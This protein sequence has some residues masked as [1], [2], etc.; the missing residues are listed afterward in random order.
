VGNRAWAAKQ[1]NSRKGF[2]KG[3]GKAVPPALWV[4]PQTTGHAFNGWDGQLCAA[5]GKPEKHKRK[6]KRAGEGW[7]GSRGRQ[8]AIRQAKEKKRGWSL[9]KRKQNPLPL[10]K[11]TKGDEVP[12]VA[13]KPVD[14]IQGGRRDKKKQRREKGGGEGGFNRVTQLDEVKNLGDGKGKS[15]REP[16]GRGANNTLGWNRKGSSKKRG[17]CAL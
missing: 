11:K 13:L 5:G 3:G 16:W 2:E 7:K 10:Q 4:C 8:V 9:S 15:Q 17:N 1:L 6:G 12:L 14:L